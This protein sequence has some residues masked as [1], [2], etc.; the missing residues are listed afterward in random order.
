MPPQ[1]RVVHFSGT[2]QGV[3]FRFTTVRVARDHDVT[4]QVRNLRDGRVQIVVEGAPEAI[5]AFL[6]E[7]HDRMGGCIRQTTQQLAEPTGQ[8]TEFGVGF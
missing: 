3:G 7:V 4:G 2:V 6:A 8:F 1:R 5:D